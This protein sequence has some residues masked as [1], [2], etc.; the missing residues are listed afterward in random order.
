MSGISNAAPVD[1][2]HLSLSACF[3]ASDPVQHSDSHVSLILLSQ[4]QHASLAAASRPLSHSKHSL[5]TQLGEQH[6]QM[7]LTWLVLIIEDTIAA[8]FSIHSLATVE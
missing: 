4:A 3:S 5:F 6:R 1:L 8:T 7:H 2:R